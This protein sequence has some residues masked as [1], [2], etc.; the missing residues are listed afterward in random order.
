[1]EILD[2]LERKVTELLN[3][4]AALRERN[5]ELEAAGAASKKAGQDES[6]KT[7]RLEEALKQEQKLREDV[8]KRVSILVQRLE[9]ASSA[10]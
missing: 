8:L 3:E 1:M 9:D 4:V 5:A 7:A 10:G 2:A 6:E